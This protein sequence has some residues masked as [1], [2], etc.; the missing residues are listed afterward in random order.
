MLHADA[1][2]AVASH[3]VAHQAAAQSIRNRPV[4]RVDVGNQIVRNEL[5]EVS[6]GDR[7]RIHG[8]VVHRLRVGQHDDHLFSALGESAFDG[9]R[10]MDFVGPLLGAD[11][12]AVQRVDDG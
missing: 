4:M 2:R 5:L 10:Y 3:R 11:R 7:T 6:G 1:G 8:T 9:L 12:I